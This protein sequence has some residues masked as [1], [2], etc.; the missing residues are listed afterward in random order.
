[1]AGIPE[2]KS[3]VVITLEDEVIEVIKKVASDNMRTVSNEIAILIK[4][5]YMK[6]KD[7]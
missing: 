2:G 6:D 4:E 7:K 3:R 5:K 1:M